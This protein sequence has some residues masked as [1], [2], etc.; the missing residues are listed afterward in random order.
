MEK[1]PLFASAAA[2]QLAAKHPPWQQLF[3]FF[4]PSSQRRKVA[5]TRSLWM[6]GKNICEIYRTLTHGGEDL[7]ALELRLPDLGL[8][9]EHLLLVLRL[10]GVQAALRRLQL[11][12]QLLLDADV[13]RQRRQVLA[14]L[15][16]LRWNKTH[17]K[18]YFLSSLLKSVWTVATHC[19]RLEIE[20]YGKSFCLKCNLL[21]AESCFVLVATQK[22]T[23]Y[24]QKVS[25]LSLL[26]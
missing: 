13:A 22:T 9:G 23:V 25:N 3:G 8:Q 4:H 7:V 18:L 19:T 14:Q 1:F 26:A 20:H 5:L 6:R 24:T 12:H 16:R 15:V 21:P 11:L 2:P 10:D 17:W